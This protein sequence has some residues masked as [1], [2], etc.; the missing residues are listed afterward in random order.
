MTKK[1]PGVIF[2]GLLFGVSTWASNYAL[3]G[4][5]T[6]DASIKLVADSDNVDEDDN[7]WMFF[8][9]DDASVTAYLGFVGAAGNSPDSLSPYIGTFANSFLVGTQSNNPLQLGTEGIVRM[10]IDGNGKTGFG[11]AQPLERL[12]LSGRIVAEFYTNNASSAPFLRAVRA[13]GTVDAPA[14][15]ISGDRLLWIGA[16]GFDGTT[17]YNYDTSMIRFDATEDW[18]GTG[19][20]TG[21]TFEVTP[22]GSLTRSIAMTI[23]QSKRVGIGTQNPTHP[24]TVNG[25]I[26]AKEIVVDT[27]WADYVFQKN[28]RLAPLSEV[29][30]HIAEN[31]HLPDM[32]AG[33]QV[34]MHGISLGESQ[35]LLLRKIEELTLHM[36]RQ[37]K[38]IAS[39]EKRNEELDRR[40]QAVRD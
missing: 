40:L 4:T 30:R 14:L 21:I 36:I 10:T 31:G 39:L 24:L 25:A 38:A 26:R 8:S 13:R 6:Q 19:N 35:A 29:E 18:S 37:E 12:H 20:G 1:L 32:P 5:A 9:Q 22:N 23:D 15:P 7:A 28:Y 16:G 11:V 34:A 3:T 2:I 33:N 27:G 17:L